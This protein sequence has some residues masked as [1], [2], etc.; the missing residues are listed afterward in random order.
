MPLTDIINTLNWT[1][2]IPDVDTIGYFDVCHGL[3]ISVE[4]Y[5]YR[6]GGNNDFVHRL[7]GRVTYPNLVLSRGVTKEDALLKW[8]QATQTQAQRK[9]ITV[10]LNGEG[11]TRTWT[12]AD[13]FPIRWSGPS[14]DSHGN[15]IASETL[16]IAHT[17][18]KPA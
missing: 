8:F 10:T 18:L 13:A 11:G 12:F 3:E 7:P 15:S 16:E 1:L 5:E 4:V 2:T 9:E 17:G 14:L 6:E